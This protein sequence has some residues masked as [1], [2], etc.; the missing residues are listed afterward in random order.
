MASTE[1]LG[2]EVRGTRGLR[3][4]G[5]GIATSDRIGVTSD[6]SRLRCAFPWCRRPLVY[7][8]IGGVLGG[9]QAFQDDVQRTRQRALLHTINRVNC[10]PGGH[11]KQQIDDRGCVAKFEQQLRDVILVL[12]C[13]RSVASGCGRGAIAGY[14]RLN[15]A[16]SAT[17]PRIA[18]RSPPLRTCLR[19]DSKQLYSRAALGRSLAERSLGPRGSEKIG[20]ASLRASTRTTGRRGRRE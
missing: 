5:E 19:C 20:I 13:G 4:D 15:E 17:D 7:G 2:P 14:A 6:M 8:R 16:G 18:R 11:H 12:V 1:T 9:I 10:L 3:V